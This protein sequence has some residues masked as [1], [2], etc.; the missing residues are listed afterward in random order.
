MGRGVDAGGLVP[1]PAGSGAVGG[2]RGEIRHWHWGGGDVAGG[3]GGRE[4]LGA[5]LKAGDGECLQPGRGL[6][7]RGQQPRHSLYRGLDTKSGL[8]EEEGRLDDVLVLPSGAFRG[9]KPEIFQLLFFFLSFLRN[10]LRLDFRFSLF[11]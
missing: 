2:Q 8:L 11:F 1:G 3:R 7:G 4:Q 6:R 5:V 10:D 9:G